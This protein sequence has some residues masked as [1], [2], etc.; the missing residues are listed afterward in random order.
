MSRPVEGKQDILRVATVAANGDAVIGTT[1][2]DA[3]DKVGK[4]GVITIEEG[5]GSE[6]KVDVVEGMQFDRGYISPHFVTDPERLECVLE[7]PYVMIWQEKLSGIRPMIPL[8]EQ[9][10][11]SKAPLVVVA[12]DVDGEALATFVVNRMK[13]IIPCCAVKAPGYGDRR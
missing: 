6:T 3:M 2:A 4:D 7:N 9:V 10:A 11:K 8:L 13:G 5:K 1:I 12:E